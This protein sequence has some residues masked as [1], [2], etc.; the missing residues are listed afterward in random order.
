MG[1]KSKKKRKIRVQIF[2]ETDKRET[3]RDELDLAI[4]GKYERN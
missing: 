4:K 3:A 2:Q 1:R